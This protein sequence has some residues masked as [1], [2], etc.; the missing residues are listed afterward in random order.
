MQ[1]A[2]SIAFACIECSLISLP[3]AGDA[4]ALAPSA[5]ARR[6]MWVER[7][8]RRIKMRRNLLF[9]VDYTS[10]S[11]ASSS[12]R[13]YDRNNIS[14]D[15]IA[16]NSVEEDAQTRQPCKRN[17]CSDLFS[18]LGRTDWLIWRTKCHGQSGMATSRGTQTITRT[19][20]TKSAN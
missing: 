17:N 18:T 14:A 1:C 4:F 13:V 16:R 7:A 8:A 11:H 5:S 15:V 6:R 3:A 19:C 2:C 20:V 12:N 9:R 10:A